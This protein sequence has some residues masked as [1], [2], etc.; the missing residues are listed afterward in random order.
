MSLQID[1]TPRAPRPQRAVKRS[2][3]ATLLASGLSAGEVAA[4]YGVSRQSVYR[5]ASASNIALRRGRVMPHP[6][7]DQ[8]LARVRAGLPTSPEIAIALGTS[9]E[10][11]IQCLYDL[12]IKGLV[13]R[14]RALDVSRS[15][16]PPLTWRVAP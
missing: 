6:R 10:V 14:G 9:R 16:R 12:E 7:Q 2:E 11:V 4:R 1:T 3:L 13:R 8:V 15:G 5:W